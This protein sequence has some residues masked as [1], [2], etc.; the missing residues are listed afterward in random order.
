MGVVGWGMFLDSF[1]F[2]LGSEWSGPECGLATYTRM[3][4]RDSSSTF[5]QVKRQDVNLSPKFT[6]DASH[7]MDQLKTDTDFRGKRG[8]SSSKKIKCGAN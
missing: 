1:S 3:H 7:P 8:E 5:C 2:T 6:K 4:Y